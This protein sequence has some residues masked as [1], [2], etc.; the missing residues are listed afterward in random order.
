[1]SL[2]L[3]VGKPRATSLEISIFDG[4][5][6]NLALVYVGTIP[7]NFR[8]LL[9]QRKNSAGEFYNYAVGEEPVE[10]NA[11]TLT[12]AVTLPGTYRVLRQSLENFSVSAGVDYFVTMAA[13]SPD[14]E[15]STIRSDKDVNG[16]FVTISSL[17]ADET[18]AKRSVLSGGTSPEY[19]TRTETWYDT[20]GV[21]VL[22]TQVYTLTYDD[23]DLVSEKLP[24]TVTPTPTVT[25]TL[26]VTPTVTPTVTQTIPDE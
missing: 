25:P 15:L 10:L 7:D 16:I 9:V 18:L 17:R 19:T 26:S 14:Q 20:D 12:A 13:A 21:T 6:L 3:A 22:S 1:M 4:Q 23:G 24:V 8:S 11:R 5:I 2:I